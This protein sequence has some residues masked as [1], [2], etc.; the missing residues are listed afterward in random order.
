MRIIPL[1]YHN[2]N[3]HTSRAYDDRDFQ[4]NKSLNNQTYTSK[5]KQDYTLNVQN[6]GKTNSDI[7][8]TIRSS[9][10]TQKNVDDYDTPSDYEDNSDYDSDA[11]GAQLSQQPRHTD[12]GKL[13]FSPH[14][15][16]HIESLQIHKV[17]K[18]IYELEGIC[19]ESDPVTRNRICPKN[20]IYYYDNF[21][22]IGDCSTN[23][24]LL[25]RKSISSG[26]GS[27]TNYQIVFDVKKMTDPYL[28]NTKQLLL[29]RIWS[30]RTLKTT[31][32]I[33]LCRSL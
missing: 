1:D 10:L 29:K 32:V 2:K 18:L 9:H 19:R 5:H 12:K 24:G 25:H 21:L 13:S 33:I 4:S 17:F 31:Q 6:R 30:D 22:S 3:K 16:I 8:T 26:W 11:G 14:Y 23:C 28:T 7:E 27:W 20:I 15:S